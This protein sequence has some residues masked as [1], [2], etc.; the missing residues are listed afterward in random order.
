MSGK[1]KLKVQEIGPYVYKELFTHDNITFN[2]NGTVSTIPRHPLVWQPEMSEGHSEDD[3]FMLPN[4][5]LLVS[6][7]INLKLFNIR[8]TRCLHFE[9]I[10]KIAKPAIKKISQ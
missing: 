6:N 9:T 8:I 10:T 4:I 5:A 1:E 2:S 7:F 3:V